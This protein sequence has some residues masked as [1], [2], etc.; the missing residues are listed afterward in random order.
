MK[1]ALKIATKIA[2]KNVRSI[3]RGR[4]AHWVGDGFPVH[5]VFSYQDLGAELTPFLLLD[6][7]GPADF[8]P[9]VEERGVGWHPHRGFE[10]VT[11]AYQGEVDHED[12]GGNRGSIRPGDVQ[13]MTAGSGVLHKE[14]HGRDYA[15]RGGPFEMLQLW[16]NLPAKSKMTSPRYQELLDRDIPAARLPGDA[17]SV[18]VIAG[19]F[20]GAKGPARTFTPINLFDLRLRAGHRVR[21]DLREGWTAALFVLKGKVSVNGEAANEGELVVFE[22]EG[23]EAAIEAASDATVFVMNGKPI[24]E[25]IAGYGPFVMNTQEQIRQAFVDYQSGR[26]GRIPSTTH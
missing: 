21:L 3:H 12:T 22:R 26:L 25:P 19:E 18:R 10:T 24:D 14:M 5:T 15:R 11:I 8:G 23:G 13:W 17:G 20:E 6:H 1:N 4:E 9:T 16:V 2:T 7:A